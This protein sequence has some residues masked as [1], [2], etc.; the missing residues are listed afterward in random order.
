LQQVAVALLLGERGDVEQARTAR[1][2]RLVGG[3]GWRRERLGVDDVRD[4]LEGRP[5]RQLAQMAGELLAD[6]GDE[7]GVLER[8]PRQHPVVAGHQSPLKAGVVLGDRDLGAAQAAERQ[9]RRRG[10]EDVG[11]DHVGTPA[12]APQPA[13]GGE[14]AEQLEAHRGRSQERA[15]VADAQR[16]DAVLDGVVEL[17]GGKAGARGRQ[18]GEH[19]DVVAGRQRAGV[20]AAERAEHRAVGPRVPLRHDEHPEPPGCR[21][22][23][24]GSRRIV[25][26]VRCAS[27]V[28][29]NGLPAR[30]RRPSSI[31]SAW[32]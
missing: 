5:G 9:R 20:L 17:E 32:V 1:R 18:R 22:R 2:S 3:G 28:V 13:P 24:D 10:L 11:V 14:H 7:V 29:T 4:D 19:D 26:R 21:A 25:S 12:L 23:H 8:Q 30:K 16:A 6:R 27:A 31:A 15:P